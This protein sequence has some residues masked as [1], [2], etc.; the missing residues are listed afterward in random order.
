MSTLE[1]QPYFP[2]LCS[3]SA[4][5]CACCVEL[6]SWNNPQSAQGKGQRAFC[7][8]LT[9]EVNPCCILKLNL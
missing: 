8:H 1:G 4:G 7:F 3:S 9:S 6:I 2:G 5:E